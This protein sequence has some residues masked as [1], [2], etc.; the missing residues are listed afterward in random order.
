MQLQSPQHLAAAISTRSLSADAVREFTRHDDFYVLRNKDAIARDAR[1]VYK[2]KGSQRRRGAS[3]GEEL[4]GLT[5][6]EAAVGEVNESLGLTS[7][8][9]PE[10]RE[11]CRLF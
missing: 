7:V 3:R 10:K 8:L 1:G 6:E 5:N 9:S 2:I 11:R 4:S